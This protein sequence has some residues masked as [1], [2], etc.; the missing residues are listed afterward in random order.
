MGWVS[1][2]FDYGRGGGGPRVLAAR[3]GAIKGKSGPGMTEADGTG[4]APFPSFFDRGRWNRV[5]TLFVCA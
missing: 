3:F 5:V 2:V 4:I 1:T